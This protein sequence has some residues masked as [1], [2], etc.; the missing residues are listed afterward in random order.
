M[1]RIGSSPSS[2]LKISA[3]QN[4]LFLA[5]FALLSLS[6]CGSSGGGGGVSQSIGISAVA[7]S[8]TVDGKDTTALTATVVYDSTNSGV[9][10][11][12]PTIG[13]LS[14]L[15]SLTPTYTAPAATASS[16]T[17]TLTATSV[18]DK[19]KSASVTLTIPAAP[20]ITTTSLP[21]LMAGAAYSTTLAGSGGIAPYTWTVVSGTLPTGVSLNATT[22]VISAVAGATTTTPA[23]NLTFQLTDSGTPTALKATAT[24]SLTIYSIGVSVSAPAT[25]VDGNDAEVL[26]AAVANDSS[27][28]GVTWTA[29]SIG[30]LSSLTS[31]T[32]TYTAPA[33][34]VSVQTVT[35]TATSVADKTKSGSVT[36]TI[37]AAPAI[38]TT[39]LPSFTEGTAYST[40]LAGSGGI[41]PYTWTLVSGTLPTGVSLNATTGEISAA[42]GA[43]TATPATNLTFQMSDSGTPTALTAKTTLSL[44]INA[45]PSAP[46][47]GSVVY[48]NSCG[49]QAGPATSVSINTNPV[50]T[51]TTDSNGN[52]SFAAIPYGTYTITPS[53]AG[54]NAIFAPATQSVTVG[55]GGAVTSFQ[56]MVGYSVSGNVSYTGTATGPV[57]IALNGSYTVGSVSYSC[58]SG[59]GTSITAPGLFTINGVP[60]GSYTIMAWRDVANSNWPNLSDPTG[61]STALTV[62]SGNQ[63]GISVALTDP[64]AVSFP[65][66]IDPLGA[67]P[68]DQGVVLNA[69]VAMFSNFPAFWQSL[70]VPEWGISYTLQW[71]TDPSFVNN[72]QTKNFPATGGYGATWMLNGLTNGQKLF[73]RY[74]GVQGST[75]SLWSNPTGPITIGAPAGSVTV[76]GKVNFTNA[77]NGPLYI[78]FENLSTNQTYYT[79]IASPVSPQAYSIQLPSDGNYYIYAFIDQNNDNIQDNGDMIALG[80]GLVNNLAVTG[81]SASHDISLYAGGNSYFLGDLSDDQEINN[82]GTTMQSYSLWGIAWSGSKKLMAMELVSGQNVI[83]P[84]DIYGC[85]WGIE[86]SFCD[87]FTL[88]G[89]PPQIGDAYGFKLT[90]SDGS[91]ET[92]P[93]T[94]A[95]VPGSFGTDATPSG[96]GTNLQPNISWTDPA[97]AS[98]YTYTFGF[99][100]GS[101][102][103]SWSIPAANYGLSFSS[104]IDSLTWGVD[105]TGGGNLPSQSSLTSGQSYSWDITATN[106]D[107]HYSNLEVGYY[108]GY[109]RVYLPVANPTT[110]GAAT[111]GHSY[112]GAIAANNGTGPYI[113]TV[114]GLCD[115]LTSSSSGGTLTISGTPLAAGTVS[116]QVT[117]FDHVGASWGPVTYTISVGN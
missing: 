48:S 82:F 53:L 85:S 27:N 106:S 49:P 63:T 57:H 105:P 18:A 25:T 36:L 110:L 42:A 108:P 78:S 90:Y 24:L 59:L 52:F 96:I 113:F 68:I 23:T 73:F 58:G 99:S 116:F 114:T 5:L 21:S 22:G 30:S 47:A 72:V 35:L 2:G 79:S 83:V 43:T 16:Q 65:A 95:S 70:S 66:F 92:I 74:Q 61:S 104:S 39:S 38:T 54:T 84:Q 40:T 50:Q 46:V 12:A 115:G 64:A 55:S 31:L 67:I 80:H 56:A 81:N 20:A 111:V 107:N 17:V 91:S 101:P 117:V 11:T 15:T 94:I 8:A 7:S 102:S 76:S 100:G 86:Y 28:S 13:S 32:P 97:N 69:S 109:T 34:T 87:S 26:T 6:G 37:P 19:T 62:S 103:E 4:L 41:A 98:D 88:V 75:T 9:T 44:T 3:A 14:S 77:A 51:T 71:S 45:P 89:N 112:T 60:P 93:Y 33:A 29:P 1:F 10:W